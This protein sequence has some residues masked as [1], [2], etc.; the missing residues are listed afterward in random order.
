MEHPACLALVD[1]GPAVS[2]LLDAEALVI[3]VVAGEVAVGFQP[4]GA[5]A[6]REQEFL[7]ITH[8][9]WLLGDLLSP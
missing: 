7:E 8:V 1:L 4:E 3:W 5:V 2:K 6:A 9:G